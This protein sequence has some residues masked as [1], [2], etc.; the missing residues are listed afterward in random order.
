MGLLASKI[1]ELTVPYLCADDIKKIR[2]LSR[3]AKMCVDRRFS[4]WMYKIHLLETFQDRDVI[5]I[6][7]IAEMCHRMTCSIENNSL[8][9]HVCEVPKN[10]LLACF[11]AHND[12]NHREC[13]SNTITCPRAELF[14]S[15]LLKY[16]GP[17]L[18]NY[19]LLRNGQSYLIALVHCIKTTGKGWPVLIEKVTQLISARGNFIPNEVMTFLTSADRDLLTHYNTLCYFSAFPEFLAADQPWLVSILK[20]FILTGDKCSKITRALNFVEDKKAFVDMLKIPVNNLQLLFDKGFIL[21]IPFKYVVDEL[22]A[23]ILSLI[24]I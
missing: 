11:V 1:F 23:C 22:E 16:E 13:H 5:V 10:H 12:D 19:G 4:Q 9:D 17:A 7:Y 24:H 14:L 3:R 20:Q 15:T 2:S 18:S 21:R 8:F 6:Y